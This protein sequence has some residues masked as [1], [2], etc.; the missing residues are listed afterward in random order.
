MLKKI[1]FKVCFVSYEL[2]TVS[3]Q[4]SSKRNIVTTAPKNKSGKFSAA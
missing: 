1:N 3:L 4:N 2:A